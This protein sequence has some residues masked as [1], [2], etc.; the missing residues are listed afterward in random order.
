[1]NPINNNQKNFL[2]NLGD[3]ILKRNINSASGTNFENLT[4]YS[5]NLN[6]QF[7]KFNNKNQIILKLKKV[8]LLA[9]TTDTELG[10]SSVQ[11]N[12][13]LAPIS[14]V[15]MHLTS[16]NAAASSPGPFFKFGEERV[17]A[18]YHLSSQNNNNQG[19]MDTTI[20]RKSVV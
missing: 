5:N 14:L 11:T 6:S 13:L 10:A 19:H 4:E 2:P 16:G 7:T 8:T 9:S 12:T 1:M 18:P 20:D 15:N 17:G 3:L